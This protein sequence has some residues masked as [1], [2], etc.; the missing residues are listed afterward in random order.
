MSLTNKNAITSF[1]HCGLCVKEWN[2][3]KAPGESPASYSRLSVGWTKEGLQ[4]WCNRHEAN[5]VHVDFQGQQ[6]PANT[7][8]D[9]SAKPE[10]R[11]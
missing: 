5:V 11:H 7:T 9:G 1:M 4:V 8:R 6:H 10:R 2:D 3:G